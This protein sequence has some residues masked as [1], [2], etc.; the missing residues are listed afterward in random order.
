[1]IW[2]KCLLDCG[3]ATLKSVAT[4]STTKVASW[5]TTGWKFE[6]AFPVLSAARTVLSPVAPY[7]NRMSTILSFVVLA[8]VFLVVPS[9]GKFRFVD[10]AFVSSSLLARQIM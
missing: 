2:N 5:D 8:T 9:L 3:S 7:W 6:A 10:R 4:R 1:M